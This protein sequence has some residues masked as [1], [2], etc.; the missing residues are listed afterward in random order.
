MAQFFAFLSEQWLLVG[1]LLT[2]VVLLI[3][4][5]SR[6]GGQALTPQ[7]L[8][9]QIN[10][11]HATVVDLRAATEFNK[12]HIVDALNIPHNKLTNRLEALADYRSQP[13]ILVCQMGQHAGTSVKLL[14][15]NGF[16]DVSRL[17]GGI[18]EW[19]RHQLPLVSK[20]KK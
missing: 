4:H 2:C 10:Q 13:L 3:K 9:N 11:R 15:A 16:T 17:S 6:R 12:G 14:K 8:V 19:Q 1:A 18:A 7:Q 5:E 20:H